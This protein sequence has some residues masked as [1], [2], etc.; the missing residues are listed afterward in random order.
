[1]SNAIFTP[2]APHNEPVLSYA[3]GSPERKAL[4][5]EYDRRIKTTI[6]APM[7]IGG[8]AVET[9]DL[10]KMSPPHKHA[11]KL[12]MSHHGDAKHVK[13][14]IDAALKA[15]RDWER[16]PWEERAAIY[17]KAADLISGPYRASINAASMLAQ[18][19]NCFQADCRPRPRPPLRPSPVPSSGCRGSR[20]EKMPAHRVS[21]T[22]H[23]AESP[24]R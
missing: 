7:W 18:S 1:M 6:D 15:K 11:H 10:L 23:V 2:P 17:L 20:R 19:K 22:A 21:R 12:G 9:K 13:A 8:K 5:T 14:A 4:Q 24:G 3:P 16:M